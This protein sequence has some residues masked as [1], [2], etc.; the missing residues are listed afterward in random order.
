MFSQSHLEGF[1]GDSDSLIENE[2]FNFIIFDTSEEA[3]QQ[4]IVVR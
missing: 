4:K 3:P 2:A 1:M